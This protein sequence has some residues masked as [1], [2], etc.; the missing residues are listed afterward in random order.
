MK[1]G[2]YEIFLDAERQIIKSSL[3]FVLVIRKNMFLLN[4]KISAMNDIT[5]RN[6][7]KF[8]PIS[9]GFHFSPDSMN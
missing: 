9:W 1:S 6:R 8:S 3:K 5:G 2:R 7:I 4:S